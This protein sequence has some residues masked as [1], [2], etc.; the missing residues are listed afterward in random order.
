MSKDLLRGSIGATL[1]DLASV[2]K[3][4]QTESLAQQVGFEVLLKF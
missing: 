1:N 3:A 2:L 4:T